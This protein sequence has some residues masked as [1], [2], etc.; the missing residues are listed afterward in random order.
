MQYV[1]FGFFGCF[2]WA[3]RWPTQPG[4]LWIEGWHIL[5]LYN[6]PMM[7]AIQSSMSVWQPKAGMSP[8]PTIQSWSP[9]LKN[10]YRIGYQQSNS[11]PP[12]NGYWLILVSLNLANFSHHAYSLSYHVTIIFLLFSHH[13]PSFSHR[14]RLGSPPFSQVGASH[15]TCCWPPSAFCAASASCCSIYRRRRAATRQWNSSWAP[16]KRKLWRKAGI[17]KIA[18]KSAKLMIHID[19]FH[20]SYPLIMIYGHSSFYSHSPCSNESNL[21]SP[22]YPRYTPSNEHNL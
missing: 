22:S 7:A 11:Y 18:G 2:W 12:S 5:A 10:W 16:P 6:L 15:G 20:C 9:Q 1:C 21:W 4:A 17:V 3:E 19:H 14:N 13:V 8:H